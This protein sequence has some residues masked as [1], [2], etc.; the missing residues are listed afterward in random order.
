VRLTE[1][2]ATISFYDRAT[3]PLGFVT[4][5]PC[6]IEEPTATSV[7]PVG[8]TLEVDAHGCL[9]IQRDASG[10]GSVTANPQLVEVLP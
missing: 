6:V 10:E 8:W 9:V 1:G 2:P 5:G 3:L 7:V 4:A